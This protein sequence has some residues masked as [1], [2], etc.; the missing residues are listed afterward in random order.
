MIENFKQ[1]LSHM[2][3]RITKIVHSLSAASDANCLGVGGIESY[4][5]ILNA[6]RMEAD[7]VFLLGRKER[8]DIYIY[9]DSTHSY[10]LRF[11]AVFDDAEIID[12]TFGGVHFSSRQQRSFK[13]HLSTTN[14]TILYFDELMV[15]SIDTFDKVVPRLGLKEAMIRSSL[16][17]FMFF[18]KKNPKLDFSVDINNI[19]EMKYFSD[20]SP[21]WSGSANQISEKSYSISFNWDSLG[22][23]GEHPSEGDVRQM[24][25]TCFGRFA[26]VD[27]VYAQGAPGF[28]WVFFTAT[29]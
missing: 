18:V 28:V 26:C 21:W 14:I 19:E 6:G 22:F 27:D 16:F 11:I 7:T 25:D 5:N 24:V 1:L 15:S 10:A 2:D 20:K 17:F 23:A 9:A 13:T 12:E 29:I 8:R 3:S 4:M